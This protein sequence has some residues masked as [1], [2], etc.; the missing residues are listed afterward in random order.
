MFHVSSQI[1]ANMSVIFS[2][3]SIDLYALQEENITR[4]LSSLSLDLLF[5]ILLF[6]VAFLIFFS[7]AIFSPYHL[8]VGPLLQYVTESRELVKY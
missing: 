5:K 7:I 2:L 4:K 1:R 3:F 6:Q 8:L